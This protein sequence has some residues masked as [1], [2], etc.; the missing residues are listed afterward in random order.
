ML[1]TNRSAYVFQKVYE[2][3]KQSRYGVITEL[4]HELHRK[5]NSQD[6]NA[7]LKEEL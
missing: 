2:G 1:I 7:G 5:M 4:Y 6:E 3:V